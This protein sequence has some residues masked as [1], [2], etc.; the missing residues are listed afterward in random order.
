MIPG[1]DQFSPDFSISTKEN[2]FEIKISLSNRRLASSSSS[3]AQNSD[4]VKH[5]TAR[6]SWWL[7]HMINKLNQIF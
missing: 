3:M 4:L 6:G 5:T 2:G 7:A 1:I